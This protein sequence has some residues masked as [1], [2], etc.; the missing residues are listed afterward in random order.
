VQL[1][2]V[3]VSQSPE[4]KFREFLASRPRPQRYTG[5]QRDISVWMANYDGWAV[6]DVP[7]RG[8]TMLAFLNSEGAHGAAIPADTQPPNLER[9]I[10]QFRLGP[11]GKVIKRLTDLM[12]PEQ[13][14][15]WAG[16]K[17]ARASGY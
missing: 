13:A 8:N 11:T 2:A 6:K 1:P 5:Q 4:D 16:A 3:A 17:T 12:P 10:Y 9:Y 7:F 14:T 15:M